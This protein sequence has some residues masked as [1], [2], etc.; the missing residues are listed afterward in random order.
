M[1]CHEN[2]QTAP[3][4]NYDPRD[5]NCIREKQW[6]RQES[7]YTYTCIIQTEMYVTKCDLVQRSRAE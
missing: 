5:L 1:F 3:T 7:A 4:S 2:G 6:T